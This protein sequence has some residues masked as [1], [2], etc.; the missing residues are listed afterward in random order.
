MFSKGVDIVRGDKR[1]QRLRT[2]FGN[3]ELFSELMGRFQ[4]WWTVS[5]AQTFSEEMG[6][7]QRW[8]IFSKVV[9]VCR[10]AAIFSNVADVLR[11]NGTISKVVGGFKNNRCFQNFSTYLEV[12]SVFNG[13]ES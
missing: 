3:T 11:R 7:Y 1:F 5:E 4:K 2:F 12:A 10:G 9:N 6:R 8:L 13:D